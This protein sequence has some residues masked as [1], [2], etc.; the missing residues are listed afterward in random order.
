MQVLNQ[1]L[2]DML[3]QQPAQSR[4]AYVL[5][6]AQDWMTDAQLTALW[7]EITR[8][9]APGERVIFRTGGKDDI[10]PGRVDAQ[11]LQRWAYQPEASQRGFD[12]DRSAI[13]GGFHVYVFEG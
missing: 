13:Y 8:T 10:L 2:T 3:A 1:S 12:A 6:D 4:Q 5:L 11:V 7:V 9:A